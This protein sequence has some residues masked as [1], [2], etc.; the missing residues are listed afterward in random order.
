MLHAYKMTTEPP[1]G[2]ET[3]TRV[4]VWGANPAEPLINAPAAEVEAFA[5]RLLQTVARAKRARYAK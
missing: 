5:Y 2:G 4:V 3:E 1:A